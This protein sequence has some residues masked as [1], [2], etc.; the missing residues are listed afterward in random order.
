MRAKL[1]P[2]NNIRKVE[3]WPA[4][5]LLVFALLGGSLTLTGC[6]DGESNVERGNREQIL[7]W[8]NGTEP[9]ELDP[10]IVTG[11]PEH[12]IIVALLEGLVLKDPA[13]L[14]PI[15]GVAKRWTISDN[16]LIYTFYLRQ[17]ARWSNGDPVTAQ[18]F[19][20]SWWRA[21]QPALGNQ[22]AYMYY[23]IKNAEAY[24]KGELEDF[25]QVGVK[26]LDTNTLQV[27]LANPTPYF[28]QLLD[29]YSMFPV[30]R[31]TIEKFGAPSERGTRW[32]R[33][34]NFVG[35][36]PFVLQRWDLNKQVVVE[37]SP[38]YWDR[39][40]VK[41]KAIHF[42]PTENVSTEE[43]MYRAGQ[44]HVTGAIPVDKIAV[45][46]EHNP[47]DL[48]IS[49][50][51]G[52]YFYRFNT[53]VPH[54]A[55]PRVRRALA[56]TVDRQA[57]VERITKGGQVPAYT[58]TPPDTLGY[59]AEDGFAFDPPAARALLAEAGYPNGEGFPTT[60]VL[61]N[62]SEGHRKLAVG[63]QQMWKTHL[64]IDV[65]LN[66]QDWKVYL[67]NVDN[68]HYQIARAGWI[69]DYVDPNTFLDM[70]VSDGGNNRTG[71]SNPE[72]DSLVLRQSPSASD[73]Q[74]R[75]GFFA[76]AEA[77]L[78]E[79]MPVLPIYFYTRNN[80]VQPSVKGMP[81]NLL[82]YSLYKNIYLE[83]PPPSAAD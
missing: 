74:S 30:H 35:N 36:G 65:V 62:T 53:E 61:Y 68:G 69:G 80:L 47:E 66:N 2:S 57:I 6:G 31:P 15:P 40:T 18:D 8:G 54:L 45:Y 21:L 71:W 73:R 24:A 49:T 26:A 70:W 20:W 37:K 76:Q 11:V 59:T 13:T 22:Y 23:V 5:L 50:Y 29:H 14:E 38:T 39:D 33:A 82:D 67:D 42:Y 34:G 28:L 1:T 12:H 63:I 56:M 27:T 77:L 16:Q 3:A 58:F 43:R 51:L 81:A 32:T 9:Q 79:E 10:H 55:D 83:A 25:E 17:E 48:R 19:V 41:L 72:Y 78:L 64:N 75:Y 46:K 52:T 4:N 7:H 60:E 44:L